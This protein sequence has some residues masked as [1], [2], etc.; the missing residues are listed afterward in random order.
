MSTTIGV[1]ADW[2]SLDAPLRLGLLHARR[3][4]RGINGEQ[5]DF[6]FDGAALAH[7]ALRNLY[8]D[9]QLKIVSGLQHP[10]HGTHNFG[11]FADSC[12]DRWGRMLMRRR[13]ERDQRSGMAAKTARLYESDYLLG[14][15]DSFRIGALRY[16]RDDAGAFLD[17]QHNMA[18]PPFVRLR[19]LEAAC[20][21]LE[22][23]DNSAQLDGWLKMLMAPGGSLGGARPKASVVDTDGHL[24]IA[25]FPS[26][27][28]EHDIGAWE[29][30]TQV[31]ADGCGVH[32]S[33]SL[34]RRFASTHHT[35]LSKRFDRTATGTRL[36]FASAMTLTG[37]TD[38]D[39]ASTGASYLEVAQVIIDHGAALDA[40]LRQLFTRIVFNI[41]VSN[42]DDHLRNHGFILVPGKGWRLSPAYDMNPSLNASGLMLNITENDNALNLE[43]VREVAPYFR[44]N[45]QRANE[46][47]A[48][49]SAV[50]RQWR[51][52]AAG[53]G[54]TAR[55]MARMEGAF[56]LAG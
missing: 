23:D 24:W 8:L 5:F 9:P 3:S 22:R 15:H 41:L 20:A 28:D 42:I 36:H 6:E 50:I 26:A 34:V 19:A 17:N 49:S 4:S 51:K 47:I 16:L 1:Y 29:M 10:A 38:G 30:V 18:A 53:L 35:F 46:I 31:L 56:A 37:R 27:R 40:D 12:P 2:H 52:V 43:L 55:E 32:T 45:V 13:L 44:L 25:K 48:A 54:L 7:P 39:D 33:P 11:V 21:G 14:V